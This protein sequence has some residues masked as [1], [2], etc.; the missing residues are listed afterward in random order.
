MNQTTP[1]APRSPL[2]Q[3][4]ETIKKVFT[5]ENLTAILAVI[6]SVK[7]PY[8]DSRIKEDQFSTIVYNAEIDGMNKVSSGI[9]AFINKRGVL[10][11]NMPK[12]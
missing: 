7:P 5:Y 11:I 8:E 2:E 12:A 1:V 6:Q 4:E 10:P 3:Y 9:I